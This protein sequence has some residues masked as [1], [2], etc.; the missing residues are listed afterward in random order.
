[1]KKSITT[2][3][4]LA[5]TIAAVAQS[6]INIDSS[7]PIVSENFDSMGEN[8]DL[9]FAWRVQACSDGPRIVGPYSSAL[10]ATHFTGGPNLASNQK[11]GT[12]NFYAT[13]NTADRAV[14]GIS[15][16]ASS[17][18][19]TRGT[20]IYTALCNNDTKTLN[21]ITVSFDVE[22]YR[23][24]SNSAGFT[25]QMYYS[26]DGVTWVS[27]GDDFKVSYDPDNATEGADV[28]PIDTK[29]CI[30]ATLNVKVEPASTIYLAWNISSSSGTNCASAMALAID[31]VV[32]TADYSYVDPLE[33]AVAVNTVEALV[34]ENFDS[35]GEG[36]DLPKGWRV[37][38]CSDGPRIVGAFH[39]ARTA[40]HF[41]GGP[42][43]ASNQKNG[44]YNFYA[45]E[46]P[47]DR[48]VGGISTNAASGN[49]TRGTNVYTALYNTDAQTINS[50]TI[51]FDVEKYR[52]GANAAGF[53]T[54]M[55]YSF[56]GVVWTSAGDDFK[57]SFAPDDATAGADIVPIATS[58]I[59]NATLNVIVAHEQHVYLA[60]NISSTTGNDC[61]SAMALAID[62]VEIKVNFGTAVLEKTVHINPA[63]VV[64]VPTIPETVRLV[65][66][67][68]SLIQR[69]QQ[70]TI[71]DRLAAAMGKD[72]HWVNHTMLG[73][74]L[75]THYNSEDARPLIES[76]EWTHV[77]LQEQSSLPRTDYAT[78]R[79]NVKM[80]V[81][82]IR[83][84]CPNPDAVIILPVNWAYNENNFADFTTQTTTLM[85]NYTAVAQELGITI[86][87][88]VL[89]YQM[90]HDEKGT[91]YLATLYTDNRHPSAKATYMAACMEY[92]IIYG[93]D[94]VTIVYEPR[95]LDSEESLLMREYASKALSAYQNVVDHHACTIRYEAIVTD[96][97]QNVVNSDLPFV[98]TADGGEFVDYV[99]T[100]DTTPGDYTITVTRDS[101]EQGTAHVKV[102]APPIST[103]IQS[104][105]PTSAK[106][107]TLYT[108]T[109]TAIT[110]PIHPGIYIKSGRKVVIR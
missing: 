36:T 106:S 13:D 86:N 48:A 71:F 97:F 73:M 79:N 20:N 12:Y 3:A 82:F 102:A 47:D 101:D 85:H 65:S 23:K 91:D 8:L 99:F 16:N 9:P 69:N 1:M 34:S 19:N 74:D 29:S 55:Y 75:A 87:P 37:Q 78:F 24:G 22:K 80:W 108:I 51:S 64:L 5:M 4:L 61:A 107:E 60:W 83:S 11:N 89:A 18:Y 41:T 72:A 90:I 43:L 35:M 88:V 77:I 14:G 17:G 31:N 44:T 70:W 54:Q 110:T 94:P 56:D 40:T 109:G 58:G 33:S 76:E 92:A 63:E 30:G 50:L 2:L 6:T 49:N 25:T 27:A 10:T 39:S 81:D 45:T 62:N 98:F 84:N 7:N 59:S 21:N 32:I 66:M 100:A 57:V 52:K 95:N 104:M 103:A 46:N 93:I 68:N 26:A 67:N 15:T 38:A 96:Q 42:N 28:V 105:V 53:T